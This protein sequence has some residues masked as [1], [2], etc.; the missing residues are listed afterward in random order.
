LTRCYFRSH[1]P[2][3]LQDFAWWS[4]LSVAEAKHG[5]E[6][7]E[8]DLEKVSIEE[9]LFRTLR[10]SKA[11]QR[12]LNTAY[13]LPVFDEFFVA[14]KDRQV[15]FDTKDNLLT[16]WDL[17]GPT[18]VIDG[19]PAGTWKRTTDRKSIDV[20]F[21][22]ALKKTDQA[23]VNQAANRYAEFMGLSPIALFR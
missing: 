10:S 17:L 19:I 7:V 11:P 9:K 4:G 2:A 18:V 21:V 6:L 20:K 14:Y 12:S 16:S 8:H 23:A 13:F 5:L 15:V 22:R 1:G 3:T